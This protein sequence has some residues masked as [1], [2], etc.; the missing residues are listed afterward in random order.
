MFHK[1]IAHG[2]W[3]GALIST[4]LGTELPGPGTIYV[5][6]TLNFQRPICLGDSVTVTVRALARNRTK[7]RVT[8]ECNV[9][10]QNSEV[11]IRGR[12]EVVAPIEKVCRQRM[13][14]P[15]VELRE[16]DWTGSVGSATVR[17]P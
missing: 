13:P 17:N 16:P 14:L 7:R 6:Q 5:S 11:V 3:G 15:Q 2:M 1:V 10:N 12:A 9:V 8:L 4:V